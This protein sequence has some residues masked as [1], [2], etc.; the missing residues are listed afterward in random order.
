MLRLIIK[1]TGRFL[2]AITGTLLMW[3]IANE[4]QAADEWEILAFVSFHDRNY[5][6]YIM[7]TGKHMMANLT[8]NPGQDM[9][10][11]WSPN[12]KQLVFISQRGQTQSF[13]ALYTIDSNGKNLKTISDIGIYNLQ[14]AWSPD[15]QRIAFVTR[16]ENRPNRDL[17]YTVQS[18]GTLL[19]ALEV[20]G[21]YPSWSPDGQHLAY[22]HRSNLY[23]MNV[24]S[25]E[26]RQVPGH[27]TTQMITWSP[28]SQHIAFSWRGIHIVNVVTGEQITL[29]TPDEKPVYPSWSKDGQT[30]V[31]YG[32]MTR[33]F[34]RLDINSGIAREI[35]R[36][37]EGIVLQN[38]AWR[39]S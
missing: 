10:P 31:F 15:G 24:T 28:D 4:A 18:D 17:I 2:A 7:D 35:S 20:S 32:A 34:Y 6:I 23:L 12:G 13:A 3:I 38:P 11:I 9:F 5:E 39:P 21:H 16:T 33:T 25:G 37:P 29:S 26:Q 22:W 1:M 30:I 19:S 8:H 36:V 14:P 27:Y